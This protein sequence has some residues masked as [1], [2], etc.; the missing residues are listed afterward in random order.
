MTDDT[1]MKSTGFCRISLA[2]L[3]IPAIMLLGGCAGSKKTTDTSAPRDLPVRSSNRATVSPSTDSVYTT[4]DKMPTIKGGMREVQRHLS[5]PPRAKRAEIEGRVTLQFVIDKEGNPTQIE[6]IQS[7]HPALDAAAKTAVRKTS[8]TPGIQDGEPVRVQYS[9][10]VDFEL[11]GK[12]SPFS[13]WRTVGIVGV[14]ALV[15][16]MMALGGA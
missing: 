4:V 10:P 11:N 6:V 1:A 8:Y 5:Y 9:M 2:L 3:L 16:L 15:T 14:S 12:G 13:I 7:A